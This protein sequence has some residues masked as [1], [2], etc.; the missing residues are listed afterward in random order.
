MIKLYI[1]DW[2]IHAAE[3]ISVLQAALD[4]EIYIPNLCWV[5]EM[6]HPPA[7]CRLCFVEI[8]GYDRPVTACTTTVE[9][10]M[11]V[12]TD[13][14]TV[15]ELQR[16]SLKLLLSAHHVDCGHC[17][18]NKNCDLQ[19]LARFLKVKLK[20]SEFPAYQPTGIIDT[21]HPGLEYN[22]DR[23]VLCGRCVHT[24]RNK[25]GQ[26]MFTFSGRGSG[27]VVTPLPPSEG[28]ALDEAACRVCVETCPTGALA[29]K[30]PE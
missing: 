22:R 12:R 28:Q 3:G 2:E 7:S 6:T 16:T 15:R 20:P 10:D 9:N 11:E 18:A 27:T 14:E 24:C 8:K 25:N 19:N 26:P 1:D 5:R 29:L 21:S 23:C 13:T 30:T 4:S 17:P